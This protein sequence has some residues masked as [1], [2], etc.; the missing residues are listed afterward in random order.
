[1]ENENGSK[2]VE[3]TDEGRKEL[4]NYCWP[5]MSEEEGIQQISTFIKYIILK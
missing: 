5:G 3:F 1:M 4:I 2:V